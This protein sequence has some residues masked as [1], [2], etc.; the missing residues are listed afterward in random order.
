MKIRPLILELDYRNVVIG[1]TVFMLERRIY[2]SRHPTWGGGIPGVRGL[3][4]ERARW[5]LRGPGTYLRD[6]R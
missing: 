6:N 3:L 2:I 1:E 5:H 4:E